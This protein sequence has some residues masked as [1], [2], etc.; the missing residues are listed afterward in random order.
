M[1]KKSFTYIFSFTYVH[2]QWF[3]T[4]ILTKKKKLLKLK[5]T[6]S[7]FIFYDVVLVHI[8]NSKINKLSIYLSEF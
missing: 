6:V 1:K 3:Y 8:D 2:I 5:N 7:K 4:L